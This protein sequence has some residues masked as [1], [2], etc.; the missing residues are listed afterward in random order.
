[1]ESAETWAE[2]V[3]RL[4]ISA[5]LPLPQLEPTTGW[6]DTPIGEQLLLEVDI[7]HA[8]WETVR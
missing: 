4:F 1:M 2:R 6:S 5:P 7:G 3:T 8:V